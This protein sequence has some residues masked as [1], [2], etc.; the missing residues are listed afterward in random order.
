MTPGMAKA[1]KQS[2][3]N[4][5]QFLLRKYE[6][7]RDTYISSEY[8]ETQT[9]SQFIT[10]F[11]KALGWDVENEACVPYHLCDVWEEKGETHGRPDYTFRINGRTVFFVEA[12]SPSPD[13]STDKHI[14]QTKKYAWNSRDVFYAGLF[15]F[16]EILFFDASLEPDDRRP[17][18]GEA[19]H[20]IFKEYLEKID[21]LWE[22]SRERVAAGSLDQFLRR[23]RKSIR[24]RIPVDKKFLD[25]LT[26]WRHELASG[27]HSKNPALDALELNDVV[28][29]LLDRIV[30]IRIAE[31]R[32]VIETRQ[33]W[34][35]ADLWEESGGRRNIMEFLVD[36]FR[37]INADFNGEI[38]KP[39]PCELVQIDPSILAKIIRRL[40]PPKSPYRFDVIGVEMLGSIYERYLG[41][42]LHVTAKQVRI[43]PKPEV[44]K[45]G[46]VFYTPKFI[47]DYIV[48]NSLRKLTVG[49]HPKD[50][51]KLRILDPACGSGSFLIGAYQYLIDWHLN[52]YREHPKEARI[53][54]MYPEMV[55]D[56]DGTFRLSFRAKSRIMVQNLYG[57]DI[58][59]QAVE[60]TMM[61]LYLKALEGE[62]GMLGPKHEKLPELKYNIRCGNSLV[63]TEIRKQSGITSD[64]LNRIRPFDWRSRQNGFGDILGIGGFDAIIGNPPYIQLSM[65][66]FRDPPVNAYLLEEFKGSMGRLNT[67][68]FFIAQAKRLMRPK[69]MLGFIIPNTFLTQGYYEDL[70]KRVLSQT[71][72]H[73]VTILRGQVFQDAVIENVILVFEK[74]DADSPSYAGPFELVQL[75]ADGKKER[76]AK[77]RQ[78][79][80]SKNYKSA[81]PTVFDKD[82]VALRRKIESLPLT[83]GQL[84]NLNQAIALK[85]DR[86][87]ALEQSR[88]TQKHRPVLDGRD[89]ERYFTGNARNYF[90]FDVSK[91]HSCKREDIFLVSEKILFRR[92]GETIIASLDTEQNYALNTLVV[93]TRKPECPWSMT[94]LLGILNS[95]LVNFYYTRF[96]KSSKEVFSEVQAR[97]V[98]QVP[99]PKL[100][101]DNAADAR[102]H[103]ELTELVIEIL[104]VR[105]NLPLARSEG[106]REEL[107]KQFETIDKRIDR[108]VFDFYGLTPEERALVLSGREA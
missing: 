60:V 54:P 89:I 62:Q 63:G 90:R 46:G 47:V 80:V 14:L 32:K 53:H 74:L 40:Y 68:G 7:D 39:H 29:R 100:H 8:N 13:V 98:G 59:P 38:F 64:D 41:N 108:L 17:R 76:T 34:D 84:T 35:I 70:R 4:A 30:F 16:E 61:S 27:I 42:T 23:D 12:K 55:K 1:T 79:D 86:A 51:A 67:F 96:L 48:E 69:G 103:A 44:R 65:K 24:Y 93:I 19:F 15:D 37:A 56:A 71:E 107:S 22:L 28:Q 45:A 52:Y 83:I 99:L 33:L 6:A 5:V 78:G 21:L 2:F 25:E 87:A 88:R 105:R 20:L 58:D 81:F 26:E 72:I 91:I 36:L 92:V 97:Q 66:E 3:A 104:A 18:D 106:E 85:Y 102:R 31:D 10:P 49:K 75:G 77:Y 94:A 57:V 9:R 73:A 82:L 95:R 50:I 43:E 101:L 11:F